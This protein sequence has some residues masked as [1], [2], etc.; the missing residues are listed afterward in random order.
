METVTT[1]KKKLNFMK[2][3]MVYLRK[4]YGEEKG[5]VDEST[6]YMIRNI[7]PKM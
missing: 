2:G 5:Q 7:G 3:Q 4:D 1:K 6:L